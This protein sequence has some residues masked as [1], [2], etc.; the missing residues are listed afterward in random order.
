VLRCVVGSGEASLEE[1]LA[2]ERRAVM[3]TMGTPDQQEGMRA[4]LEKRKPR[5]NQG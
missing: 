4:F 2:E 3:A 5:F 1:S